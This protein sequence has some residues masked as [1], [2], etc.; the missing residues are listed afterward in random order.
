MVRLSRDARSTHRGMP[1]WP[2]Y[3]S[4]WQGAVVIWLMVLLDALDIYRAPGWLFWTLLA[5]YVASLL[6]GYR[7]ATMWR[8]T[9]DADLDSGQRGPSW[10]VTDS[11]TE[12]GDRRAP[13]WA[14]KD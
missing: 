9:R 12:D 6:Y 14:D 10:R 8:R 2:V 5:I 11:R 13:S 7:R 1:R 3:A 4:R